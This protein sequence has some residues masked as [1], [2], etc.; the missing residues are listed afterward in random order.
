[1]VEVKTPDKYDRDT[2]VHAVTV[3]EKDGKYVLYESNTEFQLENVERGQIKVKK[4]VT[5][6]GKDFPVDGVKFVYLRLKINL[7]IQIV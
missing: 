1:M 2:T 4:I 5:L 3:K 6:S 7:M